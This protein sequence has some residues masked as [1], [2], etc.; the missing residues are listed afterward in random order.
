MFPKMAVSNISYPTWYFKWWSTCPVPNLGCPYSVIEDLK[1]D[2]KKS[3]VSMFILHE[4]KISGEKSNPTKSNSRREI[5]NYIW[6]GGE[7]DEGK[8]RERRR[9]AIRWSTNC[10]SSEWGHFGPYNHPSAPADKIW[11]RRTS[12]SI[13][14][15]V[16]NN[17]LFKLDIKL[18]GELRQLKQVVNKC[19]LNLLNSLK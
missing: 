16:R 14:G 19:V 10:K 4:T 7:N 5:P 6:G 11:S 15:I 3:E 17:T 1:R 13:Y 18:W 2:L 9:D 12:W 8:T